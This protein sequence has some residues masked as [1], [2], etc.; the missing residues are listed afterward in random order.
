MLLLLERLG[1][2]MVPVG[3][4]GAFKVRKRKGLVGRGGDVGCPS[5]ASVCLLLRVLILCFA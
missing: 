4:K 2:E 5:V 1:V 3:K